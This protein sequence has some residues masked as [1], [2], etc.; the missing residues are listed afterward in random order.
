MRGKHL[1]NSISLREYNII[2][3]AR[4]VGLAQDFI[5]SLKRVGPPMGIMV[6]EPRVYV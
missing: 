3:S 6:S 4:D 2:F 5:Q 1:I